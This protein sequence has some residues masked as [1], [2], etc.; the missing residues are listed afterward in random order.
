MRLRAV[1][2]GCDFEGVGQ[3]ASGRQRH[4]A[5]ETAGDI[6]GLN[7]LLRFEQRRVAA[8]DDVLRQAPERED[9]IEGEVEPGPDKSRDSAI[10][11]RHGEG[12]VY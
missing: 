5:Q 3:V 2:P 1:T 7:Q 4:L 8:Q 11:R 9:D 12:P 10:S 6:D